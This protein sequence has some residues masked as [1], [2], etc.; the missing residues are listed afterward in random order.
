MNEAEL[1]QRA[2][3]FLSVLRHAQ[4]LGLS[5]ERVEAAG[6]T[7]RLPYAVALAGNPATGVP[8]GGA[9]T[10]LMDTACGVSTICVLPE[11]EICP[12]L[13]LR[14]DYMRP[15]EPGRAIFG[16]AESYRVTQHVIFTRG[17]AHQGDPAYPVAH[18]MG[19]FMR[20]GKAARGEARMQRDFD[21]EPRP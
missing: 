3:R 13:D 9:V 11:F 16:F 12:T 5:V 4:V 14:I 21:A 18:V 6:L 17:I 2:R 1:L 15:A 19:T 8:H 7:L 20:L 10:T